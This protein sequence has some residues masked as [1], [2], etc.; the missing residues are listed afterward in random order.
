MHFA[1]ALND[2]TIDWPSLFRENLVAEMKNIKE[3]LFKEKTIRLRTMIGPPLTMLLIADG[4]LT[5]HQELDANILMP[6]NIV[7]KSLS[8]KRKLESAMELIAGESS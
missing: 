8:K 7:E 3:G 5:V 6:S 2:K 1:D 4:L